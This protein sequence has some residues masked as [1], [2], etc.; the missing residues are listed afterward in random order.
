MRKPLRRRDN[1]LIDAIE[2]VEP[3]PLQGTVWRVVGEGRDPLECRRPGGR[4]DD[5]SFDVLYT[6]QAREGAL[7]EMY[8]HLKRGQPIFPSKVRY[9]LFELSVSLERT[10]HLLDL[11]AL[12]ELGVQTD[13]Y[14]K[15]AYEERLSEYPRTQDIAEVAHFLEFD[16]M[17]APCARWACLNV[18]LFGERCGPE[19]RELV[20]SHGLI[21][22]RQWEVRLSEE[23]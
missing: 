22:W 4:W 16:G 12:A 3:I 17:L 5:G 18:I 10:L 20:K 9:E 1:T 14:G 2:A 15:L 21:D 8:F 11:S 19:S 13:G 23:V 7:A 6:S